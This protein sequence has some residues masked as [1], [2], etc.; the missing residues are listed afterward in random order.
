[1]DVG[2]TDVSGL[3]VFVIGCLLGVLGLLLAS[4]HDLIN[5]NIFKI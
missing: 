2:G 3:L 5:L 1:M 4:L